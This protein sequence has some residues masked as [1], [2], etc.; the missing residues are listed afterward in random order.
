MDAVTVQARIRLAIQLSLAA[1]ICLAVWG[2]FWPLFLR[3]PDFAAICDRI[4]GQHLSPGLHEDLA[5]TF[6]HAHRAYGG[7]IDALIATD[8]RITILL[9][10]HVGWKHNYKGYVYSTRP[11]LGGVEFYL[12][13]YG[14][15]C[16][17]FSQRDHPVVAREIDDQTCEV[18][19]DLG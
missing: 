12:D 15:T 19:F 3:R 6:P 2:I 11:L 1:T 9:K 17:V 13:Y 8:G 10:T 14:R 7:K 18:F 4:N 16:V 5:L